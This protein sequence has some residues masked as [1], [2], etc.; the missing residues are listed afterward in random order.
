MPRPLCIAMAAAAVA[1]LTTTAAARE[2]HRFPAPGETGEPATLTLFSATDLRAFEPVIRAFQATAPG[3]TVHYTEFDTNPLYEQVSTDCQAQRGVNADLVISSAIDLQVK[4]VNDGCAKRYDASWTSRL[5][6]WARWRKELFGLTFEPAVI[7]YNR[8]E[9]APA[10]IPTTRFD[11]IDL[12]RNE[13]ERFRGRVGT[14]DIELSG[15]GYILAT[16]DTQQ[17]NTSGRLIESLA[18]AGV[19]TYC[20]S[21]QMLDELDNGKLL[22]AY[23]VLGSYAIDRIADG[24]DIGIVLPDD[25]TV[26]LSRAAFIPRGARRE[27]LARRFLDFIYSAA[28]Q[29]ALSREAHLFNPI[30]G[31]AGLAPALPS[32]TAVSEASLRPIALDPTLLVGLDAQKRRM[33]LERWHRAVDIFDTLP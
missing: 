27:D 28:G 2:T 1:V 32:P 4:L 23:N 10:K 18:R 8:S 7:A 20:C 14:Y 24:A 25:Y 29:Q 17:A 11:F 12:L 21:A 19:R 13:H 5:P 31:F 30:E 6:K 3:V 16:A 22:L 15:V 9:L 26:V 33:M